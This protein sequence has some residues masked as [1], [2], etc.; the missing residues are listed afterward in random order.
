M[1]S[2]SSHAANSMYTTI[3]TYHSIEVISMWLDTLKS[4]LPESCLLETIE[5]IMEKVMGNN[6]FKWGDVHFSSS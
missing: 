2:A 3:D 6:L 5:E 1:Q 4:N